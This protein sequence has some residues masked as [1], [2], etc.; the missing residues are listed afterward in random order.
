MWLLP[1]MTTPQRYQHA[2][3]KNLYMEMPTIFVISLLST[4]IN[5]SI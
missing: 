4:S 3:N 2:Q 1:L 5:V